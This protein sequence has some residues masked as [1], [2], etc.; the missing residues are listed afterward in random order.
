MQR[1]RGIP[2]TTKAK[3]HVVDVEGNLSKTS[4]L[5]YR[6]VAGCGWTALGLNSSHRKPAS[7]RFESATL[8]DRLFR[9]LVMPG[10]GVNDGACYGEDE[11]VAVD[12]QLED[13]DLSMAVTDARA[14]Y[15]E[16]IGRTCPAR[17]RSDGRGG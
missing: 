5:P 14:T 12:I 17:C 4:L 2:L 10:T 7:L 6:L 13:E 1:L 15:V 11:T 9:E 8:G 16:D 3:R